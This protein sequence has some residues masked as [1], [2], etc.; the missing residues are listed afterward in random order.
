ML[1]TY[2]AGSVGGAEEFRPFVLF[3]C[4]R[5][6]CGDGADGVQTRALWKGGGHVHLGERHGLKGR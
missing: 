6:V 1:Q 4:A 3:A 5:E 2:P